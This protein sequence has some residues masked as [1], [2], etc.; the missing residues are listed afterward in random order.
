MRRRRIFARLLGRLFG[1]HRRARRGAGA[2]TGPPLRASPRAS[3]RAGRD[4]SRVRLRPRRIGGA[5]RCWP[6]SRGGGGSGK[7][8]GA[9]LVAAAVLA[10]GD[11]AAQRWRGRAPAGAAG[12]RGSALGDRRRAAARHRPPAPRRRRHGG[13][14]QARSRSR[15]PS[16]APPTISIPTRGRRTGGRPAAT[17][18]GQAKTP[19]RRW[20][21]AHA[22]STVAP[23]VTAATTAEPAPT[24][25]VAVAPPP[26]LP[27]TP[28]PTP[29]ADAATGPADQHQPTSLTLRA[30]Q[31]FCS[32]SLDDRPASF[33]PSY[34]HVAPG[35]HRLFCTLPGGA[36]I[37]VADYD[38]H[39]GNATESGH[40][41][42]RRR[43]TGALASRGL[44]SA[45]GSAAAADHDTPGTSLSRCAPL[46]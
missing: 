25:T 31:G 3:A 6:G 33:H 16:P 4:Q 2:R 35:V 46:P 12:H 43:A 29:T 20:E 42:R 23:A 28:T 15:R 34:D 30:S 37:F 14:G 26:R 24:T 21:R 13:R 22:P 36:K 10:A 11:R 27:A 17:P 18:P 45:A 19:H 32:P 9:G 1:R 38:L 40:R 44:S 39:A 41:P 5:R 7:L 8:V